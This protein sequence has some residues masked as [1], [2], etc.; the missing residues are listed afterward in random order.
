MELIYKLC[1][2]IYRLVL[3]LVIPVCFVAKILVGAAGH[4]SDF[5]WSDYL[6]FAFSVITVIL[7]TI[8]FRNR[9]L[10]SQV[11]SFI[12]VACI[13]LV[14]ISVVF[15]IYGLYDFF[16]NSEFSIGDNIGLSIVLLFTIITLIVLRR[17]VK[18]KN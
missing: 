17:I 13:I 8:L 2:I 10:E 15:E 7:L 5:I 12:R 4:N 11:R 1:S 6:L 9:E 18:D 3:A 14:S 16:T